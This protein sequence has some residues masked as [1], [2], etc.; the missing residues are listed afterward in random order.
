MA[1]DED[2]EHRFNL[3]AD[4]C[5]RRGH[6]R[7]RVVSGYRDPLA[8][9]RLWDCYQ[10]RL[11]TGRCPCPSCNT[12][13]RP[14][15][16]YHER[17]LAI[18]HA[19]N[20]TPQ[21]RNIAAEFGLWYPLLNIG[22]PWHV[23]PRSA[24]Q[25]GYQ[26]PP[27]GTPSPPAPVEDDDVSKNAAH[28]RADG[29]TLKARTGGPWGLAI[30]YNDGPGIPLGNLE[31]VAIGEKVRNWPVVVGSAELVDP[32]VYTLDTGN[33]MGPRF[34]VDVVERDSGKTWTVGQTIGGVPHFWDPAVYP[35]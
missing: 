19:P 9:K 24:R 7:P 4:E 18:D 34:H 3:Y 8:Q 30:K 5:A 17:G 26:P 13:A 11:R 22:E 14:G 12:A 21:M 1:L 32:V 20:S 6:P 28:T 16:S 15:S 2:F 31:W 23:E 29:I 35:G 25:P 27:V 10:A 33:G